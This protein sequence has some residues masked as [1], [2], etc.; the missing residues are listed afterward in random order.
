MAELWGSGRSGPDRCFVNESEGT[1]QAGVVY[2]RLGRAEHVEHL[3]GTHGG[4]DRAI[5]E[6]LRGSLRH[7]A[8]RG[9]VRAW[10]ELNCPPLNAVQRDGFTS[11]LRAAEFHGPSEEI[12]WEKMVGAD[13]PRPSGR[14]GFG[15]LPES[16][17]ARAML[18]AEACT[19]SLDP[20]F[21][22]AASPSGALESLGMLADLPHQ[23]DWWQQA[24]DEHGRQ[25]G[26]VLPT[27]GG[28]R[29]AIGFVGVWP[30]HRGQGYIDD[31]LT[32]GLDTLAAAGISHVHAHCAVSNT[33]MAAAL[34]RCGFREVARRWSFELLLRG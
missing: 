4:E 18:L 2:W 12:R 20:A 5:L 32:R 6:L 31:L 13:M 23:P 19:G 9:A 27:G 33:P 7:L 16:F 21:R 29:G 17:A 28:G 1:W 25:V 15:T 10:A 34:A 26:L 11:L 3:A 8:D 30:E 22:A 24:F 14:L